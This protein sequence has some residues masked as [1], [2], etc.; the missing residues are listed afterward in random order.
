MTIPREP[1]YPIN[2]GNFARSEELFAR[3]DGYVLERLTGKKT[4]NMMNTTM[5]KKLK[6]DCKIVIFYL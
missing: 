4:E 2:C 6:R 3:A 1:P 5:K